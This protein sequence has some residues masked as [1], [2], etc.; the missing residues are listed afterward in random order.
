MST[1]TTNTGTYDEIANA[2]KQVAAAS[3]Y[4]LG[5]ITRAE[6]IVIDPDSL[7]TD[8]YPPATA[9]TPVFVLTVEQLQ[10]SGLLVE[11]LEG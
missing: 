6:H 10:A 5:R 1:T 3:G 2:L 11:R 8:N 7:P 4:I 9:N